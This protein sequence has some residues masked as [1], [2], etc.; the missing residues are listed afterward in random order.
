ME[1]K[2]TIKQKKWAEAF[3]R[4]RNATQACREAGY[5]GNRNVLAQQGKDNT[6][7][8]R[9]QAYIKDV[10]GLDEEAEELKRIATIQEV[11]EFLTQGMRGEIK[12]QFGL[13]AMM[14]D[15]IK[16][17]NSLEKILTLTKKQE[18]TNG[19]NE[20]LVIQYEYGKPEL[21][22]EDG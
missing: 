21:I 9:I 15:R 20:T 2:L 5:K 4:T 1:Y 16:C 3:V 17:A 13:D 6:E 14:S 18:D 11:M 19:Q 8:P 7:N 10:L 22:K 12:D